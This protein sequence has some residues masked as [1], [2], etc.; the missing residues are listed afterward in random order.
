MPFG[1]KAKKTIKNMEETDRDGID[2]L[3]KNRSGHP[4]PVACVHTPSTPYGPYSDSVY[5]IYDDLST[6]LFKAESLSDFSPDQ[7]LNQTL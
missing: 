5:E 2:F 4:K 3:Q 6:G 7:N 1:T